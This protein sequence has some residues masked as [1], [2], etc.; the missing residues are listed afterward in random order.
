MRYLSTFLF[1][2]LTITIT[3]CSDDVTFNSMSDHTAEGSSP[4]R[5][6]HEAIQIALDAMTSFYGAD[7]L[8]RSNTIKYLDYSAP[9]E[10]IKNNASR[11]T[12]SDTL[13]YVVNFENDNGFA[14]VSASK[15]CEAL[16]AITSSGHYYPTEQTDNPGFNA[17]ME[18]AKEYASSIDAEYSESATPNFPTDSTYYP[19]QQK[20]WEETTTLYLVDSQITNSWG[21]GIIGTN[22]LLNNPEG[23]YFEN[24]LCGCGPLAIAQLCLYFKPSG[25]IQSS[26][27]SP[28]AIDW[29]LVKHHK[30]RILYLNGELHETGL[31][32]YEDDN[33]EAH[34]QVANLCRYIGDIANVTCYSDRTSMTTRAF[35]ATLRKVLHTTNSYDLYTYLKTTRISSGQILLILGT[36]E[37]NSIGHTW[38]CDGSK[39]IKTTHYFATRDN[40]LSNWEIQSE[41]TSTALYNHFNWGWYGKF[42]GWFN[43]IVVTPYQ[44]LT[45]TNLKYYSIQ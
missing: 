24:G 1:I 44:G 29:D 3:S 41:I 15:K 23:Y 12:Y 28:T 14:I 42:N 35:P 18:Y 39:E 45:F 6:P 32:M 5:T 25:E 37:D 40:N 21:Q 34:A 38:L 20:E 10:I 16:L 9:V 8:S 31:C 27:V 2:L 22:D 43:S 11:S 4:T 7:S 26:N 36:T 17:W 19:I 30:E 13:L 33:D